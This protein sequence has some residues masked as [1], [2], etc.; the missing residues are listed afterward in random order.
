MNRP[1]TAD[2]A[3]VRKLNT[4][5]VMEC[6]RLCAP[7]SRAETATRTGL[8]RSTVS[9]IV[10]ELIELGF[11]YETTL[12]E[13]KIGRPGML[14]QLNPQGGFAVGIEIGVD[15]IC[16]V[17]TNFI[18]EVLWRSRVS[19]NPTDPQ[20]SILERAEDMI[21]QAMDYGRKLGLRPLGIGAAMPGLVDTRQGK[22]V[23]A[24]N[25]RWADMPVRLIWMQRFN[26]HVFVEN[27][28]NC[29]ALGE[30]FY[31]VAHGVKNLVYLKTGVGLGGGILLDGRLFRGSSGYGG[32]V[33]HMTIYKGGELCG[34]GRRGCWETYVS[35]PA[36]LRQLRQKISKGAQSLLVEL[37]EGDLDH[38]T[39]DC[40]AQAAQRNDALALE[41]MQEVGRH[42]AVGTAN[43]INIFDPE[44]VVLGGELSVCGPWLLPVVRAYIQENILLP[45]REGIRL[46][47]STQGMD[48]SVIG[49]VALVLDDIV[50]E[51]LFAA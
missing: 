5:S 28:A 31:G 23:Y 17:A 27:E 16:V 18:A 38:L 46:E 42:L 43:L 8:N 6:I 44:L 9:S 51:P 13:P 47:V 50:R 21:S 4:A 25:L 12:A 35:P 41:T 32:E 34:C 29:A 40:L 1:V 15:F 39:M 48:A 7:L 33:G 19:I 3:L 26:L 30:F 11:V 24:P 22:L 20:I 14:L 10:D 49:A 37:V 2:Q 45:L 36:I